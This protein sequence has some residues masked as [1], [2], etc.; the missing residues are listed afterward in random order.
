MTTRINFNMEFEDIYNLVEETSSGEAAFN[1]EE[2][3]ALYDALQS[4]EKGEHVVEIGVQF[5]RSATVLGQVSKDRNLKLT[6]VDNWGEDVSPEA[7]ANIESQIEKYKWDVEKMW[8]DSEKASKLFKGE[9]GLIH[10]DGDHTFEGVYADCTNWLPKVRV[11]GY[12]CF[13][14]YG[15]DSLPG[16]FKA[17]TQYM[18]K[19][20]G[21]EF[22]G[23]FGNKIG[24]FRKI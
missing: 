13:D 22:I 1:K 20:G 24:V 21:W 18:S 19:Y 15:H 17:V 11:G 10:I 2:C 6:L 8:I 14:D 4:L 5:G 16:V 3:K 12:A 9:I 23:R 7:K